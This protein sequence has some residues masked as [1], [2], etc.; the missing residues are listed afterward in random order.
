MNTK[1][2]ELWRMN[3]DDVEQ[4]INY[5]LDQKNFRNTLNKNNKT[6]NV[7]RV[8]ENKNENP[9]VVFGKKFNELHEH[10]VLLFDTKALSMEWPKRRSLLLEPIRA[11]NKRIH[12]HDEVTVQTYV[13]NSISKKTRSKKHSKRGSKKAHL[14]R[15]NNI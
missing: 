10:S 5:Y 3:Q 9:Q 2:N 4:F 14:N 8:R 1:Y 13:C 7:Y 11:V 15:N 6:I 12:F